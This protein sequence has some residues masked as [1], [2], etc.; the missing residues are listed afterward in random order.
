[1]AGADESLRSIFGSKERRDEVVVIC[2]ALEGGK[3]T[4]GYLDAYVAAR[5]AAKRLAK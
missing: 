1:M 4:L 3:Q 2:G 5:I